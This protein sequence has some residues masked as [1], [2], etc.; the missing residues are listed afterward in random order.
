MPMSVNFNWRAAQVQIPASTTDQQDMEAGFKTLADSIRGAR[1]WRWKKSEQAR[2]NRIED[3]DRARRIA[4]E[5]RKK[6]AYGEAA[7]MM[8]GELISLDRLMQRRQEI[9]S[10]M[11]KIK[12]QLGG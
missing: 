8:R 5:D 4:E 9:V 12:A 10:E 1:E 11:E 2:R 6:Q 3:E 7:D